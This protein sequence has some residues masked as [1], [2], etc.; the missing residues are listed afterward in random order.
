MYGRMNRGTRPPIPHD[1]RW[2]AL[3]P[4]SFLDMFRSFVETLF[5]DRGISRDSDN[6]L[7]TALSGYRIAAANEH[8]LAVTA[9]SSG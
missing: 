5:L 2:N 9:L 8:G 4:S 1:H 3:A 6:K 7:T